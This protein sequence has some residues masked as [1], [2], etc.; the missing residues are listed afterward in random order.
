M[1]LLVLIETKNS[2]IKLYRPI[3]IMIINS[4]IIILHLLSIMH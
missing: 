2:Y 1:F 4:I 3:Y